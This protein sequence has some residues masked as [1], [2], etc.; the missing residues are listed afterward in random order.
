MSPFLMQSS[1]M[2]QNWQ[3]IDEIITY[4]RCVPDQ[5]WETLKRSEHTE[6]DERSILDCF[7]EKAYTLA[8]P[9]NDTALGTKS[10]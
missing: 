2:I 5:Y 10:Q 9:R 7:Q 3:C 4:V 1:R 6:R 8:L